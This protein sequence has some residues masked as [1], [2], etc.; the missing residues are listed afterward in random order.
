M[1]PSI[2]STP[3]TFVVTVEIQDGMEQIIQDVVNRLGA[4]PQWMD[5]VERVDV[6]YVGRADQKI[7]VTADQTRS[8]NDHQ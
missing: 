3:H 5:G 7:I 1:Q 2:P 6:E 4:A 8:L